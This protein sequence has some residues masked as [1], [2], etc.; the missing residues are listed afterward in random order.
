MNKRQR[1]IIINFASVIV[2]T[3]IAVIA[4]INFKDYVN[5]SEAMQAMN[6]LSRVVLDYRKAHGSSPPEP[7]ITDIMEQLQG[8]V[9]LGKI[10]YRA[11]WIDFGATPDEILA[12]VKKDYR[13]F[14]MHKGYIVL[15]LDGHVEW[16][17]P[18][19]FEELLAKQQKPMEKEF[20]LK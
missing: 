1:N 5:W 9:R 19:K 3:A 10:V 11:R 20:P 13:T 17:E 4:L 18:D 15:R 16:M 14:I 8:Q 7:Y 12:Y 2:I 6:Q